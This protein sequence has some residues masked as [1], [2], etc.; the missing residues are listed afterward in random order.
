MSISGLTGSTGT[1][2]TS[3]SSGSQ[4]SALGDLSDNYE[5]FLTLLTSQLQNQDPLQPTDTAEFTKQLVQ[6]SQVEQSI[7]TNQKLDDV[8]SAINK[9]Q[10]NQ[11]LSYLSKTVEIQSNG[12]ALQDGKAHLTVSTDKPAAE[13]SF[14]ITDAKTGKVVRTMALSKFAGTQDVNWDGLDNSGNQL[15]DGTY[16]GVAKITGT[17]GKEVSAQVMSF[18]RVT[19]VD[20]TAGEPYLMLGSLP[21]TMTNVLSIKD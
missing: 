15:A 1:S 7:K 20:L 4:K 5:T 10:P 16:K 19:G 14:E 9:G 17:D 12:I 3:G 8:V 21:I 18:G 6:Y 2:G 13:A 11:A